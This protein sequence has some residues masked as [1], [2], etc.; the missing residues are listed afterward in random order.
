MLQKVG[1]K[2]NVL[3]FI[4]LVSDEQPLSPGKVR[5]RRSSS[6][7]SFDWK[8]FEKLCSRSSKTPVEKSEPELRFMMNWL[9][10]SEALEWMYLVRV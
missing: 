10:K 4:L 3:E 1:S 8:V 7:P 5:R 9:M 2:F 6:R